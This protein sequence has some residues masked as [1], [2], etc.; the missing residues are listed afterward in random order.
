M[1]RD[2][3]VQ[4]AAIGV[5]GVGT[6]LVTAYDQP[7]LGGVYKLAA[8]QEGDGTWTP[9]VKLSETTAKTSLPGI[10]QVRRYASEDGRT[11]AA[12]QLWNELDGEPTTRTLI[13][14]TDAIRRRTVAADRDRK[15]L[16][17]PAVRGGEVVSRRAA[18][19]RPRAGAGRARPPGPDRPPLRQAAPLPRRRHA[20]GFRASAEA[21]R[22][23]PARGSPLMP[24]TYEYARPALTVDVVV[25]AFAEGEELSVMLIERDLEPFAGRWALPGGFVHLDE[26]I[27]EAARRELEEET[28]LKGLFL[29]QLQTFGAV[30]RDPRERVISVAHYALAN[31]EGHDVRATTD[32]R[33]A[34]W[35]PV[36]DTPDLAFDH[37]EIL[38]RRARPAFGGS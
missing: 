32:A 21:H 37:D 1:I 29:E 3:K 28:G 22:E 7:A 38:G 25:F 30:D 4:G 19:R 12:D 34:A 23:A 35:F 17:L 13:D 33:N 14:P 15:D 36:D 10:L 18:H 6:Q 24:F 5:W 16:L 31:L 2:L 8:L 11:H 20:R 27:E 26:T 9:K